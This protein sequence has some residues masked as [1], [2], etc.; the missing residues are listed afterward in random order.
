MKNKKERE[1]QIDVVPGSLFLQSSK[2]NNNSKR[3]KEWY[4]WHLADLQ[5]VCGK[6][7]RQWRLG[8]HVIWIWG[9]LF[10]F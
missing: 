5:W 4:S 3:G 1:V 6:H 10:Y 8:Q 7:A 9:R 2:N